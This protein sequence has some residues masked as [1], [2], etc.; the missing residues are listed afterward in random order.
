MILYCILW[1][2]FRRNISSKTLSNFVEHFVEHFVENFVEIFVES[3]ATKNQPCYLRMFYLHCFDHY[4]L[5]FVF[6]NFSSNSLFVIL[7]IH[8]YETSDPNGVQRAAFL[9]QECPLGVFYIFIYFT[10]FS[11]VFKYAF[12]IFCIVF[13]C[14]FDTK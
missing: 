11:Y 10:S 12:C 3:F 4:L 6:E 8:M 1:L 14:I 9:K 13:V 2:N 7:W 5:N